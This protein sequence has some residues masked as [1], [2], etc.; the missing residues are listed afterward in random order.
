MYTITNRK[1]SQSSLC[2]IED[3]GVSRNVCMLS[4]LFKLHK[5]HL[6]RVLLEYVMRKTLITTT[7]TLVHHVRGTSDLKM[8]N[9]HQKGE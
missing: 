7:T 1:C 8:V 6:E 4:Y 2:S 5:Q 9:I 3:A